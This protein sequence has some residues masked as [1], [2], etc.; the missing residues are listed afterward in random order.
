M[1][2][3]R[4]VEAY[5]MRSDLRHVKW[6]DLEAVMGDCVVCRRGL[7]RSTLRVCEEAREREV[8]LLRPDELNEK[9]SGLPRNDA[10]F[11]M[12]ELQQA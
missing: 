3:E 1:I 2:K 8:P 5:E 10:V 11:V 6:R 9:D 4:I 7:Y 12:F